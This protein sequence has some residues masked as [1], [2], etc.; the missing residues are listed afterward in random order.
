MSSK[1]V[2]QALNVAVVRGIVS[3]P[4]R[5]RELPSGDTI[6]NVEVT[7][8]LASGSVSV[9]TV[10]RDGRVDVVAGDEV[11]VIGHVARRFFR[12]GGGTQ[13]RTEVVAA[14]IIKTTKTKT[15]ERALIE[16][17]HTLQRLA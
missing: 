8:P 2:H 17:A 10:V 5:S 1:P 6:T 7:T 13:S 4:P 14:H 16:A 12:V 15:V 11:V 3:S 9:P